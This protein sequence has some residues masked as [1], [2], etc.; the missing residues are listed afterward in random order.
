MARTIAVVWTAL[1]P[2]VKKAIG[3]AIL[4]TIENKGRGCLVFGP[5]TI[6]FPEKLVLGDHVRIGA[7]SF[8]HCLGGLTIGDNTSISNRVTIY[9]SNHDY[10]GAAIP[11]DDMYVAKPVTIGRHVWIGMNASITPGV[12][13]GDGAII[14]MGTVVAKDVAPGAI[15]VGGAQRTAGTRDLGVFAEKEAAHMWFGKLFT[16]EDLGRKVR[17]ANPAEEASRR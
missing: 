12:T 8:F 9:T 15:V 14:G 4:K 17:A 1:E 3:E 7:G 2:H 13:I 10:E 16:A 11:Y 5:A 6:H